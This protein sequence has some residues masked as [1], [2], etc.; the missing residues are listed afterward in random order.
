VPQPAAKKYDFP[1][2]AKT[3]G[4]F[5]LFSRHFYPDFIFFYSLPLSEYGILTSGAGKDF[6]PVLRRFFKTAQEVEGGV[7]YGLYDGFPDW[8][9][10]TASSA[11]APGHYLE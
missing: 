2:S 5:Y 6:L 4:F 7:F 11:A 10:R 1:A 3:G 9:F 8:L